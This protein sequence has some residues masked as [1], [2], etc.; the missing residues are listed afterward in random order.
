MT[1]FVHQNI[2]IN[3]FN[4]FLEYKTLKNKTKSDFI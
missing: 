2:K 3:I 4:K 1:C